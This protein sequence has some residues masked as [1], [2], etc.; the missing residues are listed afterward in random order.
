MLIDIRMSST[1]LLLTHSYAFLILA[2]FCLVANF[3][4]FFKRIADC[5]G[6]KIL[7]IYELFYFQS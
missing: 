2:N 7:R 4:Y 3:V 1:D 6:K 5:K